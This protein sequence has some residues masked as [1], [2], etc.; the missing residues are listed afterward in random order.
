MQNKINLFALK[1][2]Y[3]FES[4][5]KYIVDLTKFERN[6]IRKNNDKKEK[7]CILFTS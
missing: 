2:N 1:E 3:K 4:F 7:L 5:I 6:E